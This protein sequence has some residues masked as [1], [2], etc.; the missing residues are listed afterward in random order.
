MISAECARKRSDIEKIKVD[1]KN[2]RETLM[3]IETLIGISIGSGK[4]SAN[5]YNSMSK[6]VINKLVENGYRVS[7]HNRF[8][9][10]Y[11][12]SWDKDC[13]AEYV[14]SSKIDAQPKWLRKL[15]N[16][17]SQISSANIEWRKSWGV[18]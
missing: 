16:F 4:H 3:F 15:R 14:E 18:H 9:A 2:D 10:Y 12:I 13:K 11:Q 8:D 17:N 7:F 5:F 1:E 6:N